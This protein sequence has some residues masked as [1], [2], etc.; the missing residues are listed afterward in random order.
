MTK[1]N[2]SAWLD[3]ADMPTKGNDGK[4]FDLETGIAYDPAYNYVTRAARTTLSA[5]SLDARAV[6]KAFGGK[7]LKGTAKQK[8]WAEKIRA[9]KLAGMS[10]DQAEMS[11]D[12]QGILTNS[13]F[14]IESRDKRGAEIGQFVIDQKALLAQARALHAA[15]KADEY[16]AAAEKYNAL[17]AKWGF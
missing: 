17:T 4:W 7:A 11:C 6:A 3:S 1:T 8:E 16:R 10:Q 5:K 13:K 15:G 9:E 14:W 12:P 2:F